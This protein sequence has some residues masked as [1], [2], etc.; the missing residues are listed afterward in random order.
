MSAIDADEYSG[1]GRGIPIKQGP[2]IKHHQR[3][4]KAER[5]VTITEGTV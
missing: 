1:H 5:W 4:G 3:G 2:L